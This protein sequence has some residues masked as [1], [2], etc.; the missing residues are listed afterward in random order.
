M[1]SSPGV[2]QPLLLYKEAL[3]LG[4]VTCSGSTGTGAPEAAD[5][6]RQQLAGA[7]T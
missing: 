7:P 5:V 4:R 6:P 2:R 1:Q 3:L